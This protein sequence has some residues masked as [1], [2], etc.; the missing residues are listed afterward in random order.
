MEGVPYT[1]ETER[2]IKVRYRDV[3][4]GPPVLLLHGLGTSMVTW[5][6]NLSALVKSG[7]RVLAMD[8]PGHGDSDKPKDLVYDPN[9][10]VE[11][12]RQFLDTLGL[13]KISLVGNSAGGLVVGM[14][15]LAYPQRV[16]KLVLVAAGGLGREVTWVLRAVSVPVLGELLYQPALQSPE[17]LARHIFHRPPPF[18]P[19]VLPEMERVR[20][21]PGAR[22][23]A[24]KSIRSSISL[25]GQRKERFLL[26]RL[27]GFPRPVLTVWGAND[28]ILP[29][30][31]A[32]A[33]K[34]VLPSAEVS[35][36]PECGHWPHMEKP[37]LF[38]HTLI[39]FLGEDSTNQNWALID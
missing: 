28:A 25:V 12:I 20:T 10:A 13:S 30:S 6:Y 26:D 27:K 33:A 35:I 38:N 5:F 19:E 3:G 21:L 23:A 15:S 31:Q 39:Q 29:V 1:F 18:L 34:S 36:M 24:I 14:F 8:L 32:R 22:R 4:E 2:G 7:F 37:E 16:D 17:N 11:L 9:G